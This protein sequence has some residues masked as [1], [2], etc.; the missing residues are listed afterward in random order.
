M[1]GLWRHQRL[2]PL[3]SIGRAAAGVSFETI[4]RDR[5]APPRAIRREFGTVGSRRGLP[6]FCGTG[7]FLDLR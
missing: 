4:L 5:L 7:D 2:K 6:E 3:T 1:T